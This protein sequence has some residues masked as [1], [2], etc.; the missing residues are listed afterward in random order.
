M[1]AKRAYLAT[2]LAALLG[3]TAPAAADD[4]AA[5]NDKATATDRATILNKGATTDTGAGTDGFLLWSAADLKAQESKLIQAL[6]GKNSASQQLTSRGGPSATMSHR[7]TSGEAEVHDGV[8]DLFYVQ[9]GKGEFVI[10]GKVKEGKTP[11]PGEVRGPGIDGGARRK[12]AAGDFVVIPPKT[13]HQIVLAP[14]ERITYLV[15][16]FTGERP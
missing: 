13:A 16:K 9:S 4:K 7:L 11:R 14:G 6:A 12:V 10:G 5:N 3:A 2:M 1:K 8:S 15:V